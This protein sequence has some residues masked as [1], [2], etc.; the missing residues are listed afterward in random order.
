MGRPEVA[1]YVIV[2]KLPGA[3]D[4]QADTDIVRYYAENYDLHE[5][6]VQL[7][8]LGRLK[9]AWVKERVE[10]LMQKHSPVLAGIDRCKE[11]LDP[12]PCTKLRLA[13]DEGNLL[14]VKREDEPRYNF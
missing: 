6:S 14:I 2:H 3:L 10:R 4:D 11:D 9:T 1:E 8:L 5:P 12:Y 13:A 7:Q